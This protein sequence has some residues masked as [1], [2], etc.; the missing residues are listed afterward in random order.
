M[1]IV[2]SLGQM[3]HG[4]LLLFM[5]RILYTLDT[6]LQQVLAATEKKL[7]IPYD[8]DSFCREII[9]YKIKILIQTF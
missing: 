1:L 4:L 9:T 8:T 2:Y 7:G 5:C 3:T 6:K